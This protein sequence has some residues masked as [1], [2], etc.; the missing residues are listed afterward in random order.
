M[1]ALL[2]DLQFMNVLLDAACLTYNILRVFICIHNKEKG[3]KE[4]VMSIWLV[5]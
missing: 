5:P 1:E 3:G 2:F 4:K